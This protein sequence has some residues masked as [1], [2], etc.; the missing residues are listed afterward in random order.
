M[1][2]SS[3]WKWFSWTDVLRK[4]KINLTRFAYALSVKRIG[5]WL[6]FTTVTLKFKSKS[7]YSIVAF[8]IVFCKGV[9]REVARSDQ[10]LAIF[11][12][13]D[14]DLEPR[15]LNGFSVHVLPSEVRLSSCFINLFSIL[16]N[17]TFPNY[18]HRPASK[19]ETRTNLSSVGIIPKLSHSITNVFKP[20]LL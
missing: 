20:I 17:S 7:N 18:P 8:Q 5:F 6:V 14:K 9:R 11:L 4:K 19:F 12:V 1:S 2:A 10:I 3:D 16:R 15:P 13:H